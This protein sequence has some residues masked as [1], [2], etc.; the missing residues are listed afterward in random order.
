[1][2]RELPIIMNT[3]M[4]KSIQEDRK[5]QTRRP[6]KYQPECEENPKIHTLLDTTD[7]DKR[8]YRFYNFWHTDLGDEENFFR[9][10]YQIGDKLYVRET[11]HMHWGEPIYKAAEEWNSII[12]NDPDKTWKPSIH[13]PKKYARIWLEVTNVRVERVQDV[14]ADDVVDEGVCPSEVPG[15]GSDYSFIKFFE[16]L[17]NSIYKNWNDNPWVWVFEFK[18]IKKESEVNN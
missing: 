15:I 11:F 9:T 18:V 12:D 8:K 5:T 14:S 3:K 10:P 17:W 16:E 6:V 4:V 13:M 7:R 1:M 2:S